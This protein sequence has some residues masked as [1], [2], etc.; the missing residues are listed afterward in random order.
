MKRCCERRGRSESRIY[1]KASAESSEGDGRKRTKEKLDEHAM[2]VSDKIL[3]KEVEAD[4]LKS[5]CII[6]WLKILQSHNQY[7]NPI[8]KETE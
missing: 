7:P 6:L 5:H 8:F 2:I 1:R 3:S 4:Q